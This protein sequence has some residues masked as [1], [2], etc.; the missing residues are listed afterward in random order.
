L[1]SGAN[2]FNASLRLAGL[3][4]SRVGAASSVSTG[5]QEAYALAGTFNAGYQFKLEGKAGLRADY[6]GYA[7]FYEEYS[8]YNV[9]DQTVSME[10][11]YGISDNLLFSLPVTYNYLIE[12]HS[13]DS[14]RISLI[15]TVTWYLPS[16]NQAVAVSATFAGIDDRDEMS[17][18]EDGDSTG[19]GLAYMFSLPK[20]VQA[21][22]S[23]DFMNTEYDAR[24]VDYMYGSQSRSRRDDD[25]ISG[26]LDVQYNFTPRVGVFGSYTYIHSESNVELY[27]YGRKIVGGGIQLRY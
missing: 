15:P 8:E 25:T 17:V 7:D 27:D 18:D 11:Q 9:V 14:D 5:G 6:I 10:P 20:N 22:L 12:D 3:Y 13:T 4:D 24:L 26:N 19:I 2:A 1:K 21:K 23:V 16:I